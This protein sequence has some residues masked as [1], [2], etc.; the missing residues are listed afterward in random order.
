MRRE[1]RTG[2]QNGGTEQPLQSSWAEERNRE[3]A[4]AANQGR[5]YRNGNRAERCSV[6]WISPVKEMKRNLKVK[7]TEMKHWFGNEGGSSESSEDT[8]E[9]E[10]VTILMS[11]GR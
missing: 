5:I 11:G 8:T 6:N 3:L 7:K 1:S 4:N 10:T 2:E 9:E